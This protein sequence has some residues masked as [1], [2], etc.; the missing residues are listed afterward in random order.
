MATV[1]SGSRRLARDTARILRESGYIFNQPYL[2]R[3]GTERAVPANDG[4]K[5]QRRRA[6]KQ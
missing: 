1:E 4:K 3:V 5:R 6:G 2:D